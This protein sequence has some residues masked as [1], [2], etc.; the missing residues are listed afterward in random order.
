MKIIDIKQEY[1]CPVTFRIF[2]FGL[3]V[4]GLTFFIPF[5][6]IFELTDLIFGIILFPIGLMLITTRYGLIIDISNKTYT[7][8]VWVL[9]FKNGKAVRFNHIEKFYINQ[10]KET[11]SISTYSGTKRDF[12]QYVYKAFMLLDTEEKIH[13]DTHRKEAKITE[14]VKNY[15]QLASSLVQNKNFSD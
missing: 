8:Y 12:S 13:V 1:Y 4:I 5:G 10:V 6:G 14:K 15:E 2:G 11:A 7:E 9:G 3:A